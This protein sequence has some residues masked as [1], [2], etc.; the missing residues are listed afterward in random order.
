MRKILNSSHIKWI[1][2]IAMF[3]DHYS[4]RFIYSEPA[5]SIGRS[6]G[7]LAFPLFLFLLVIGYIH[8]RNRRN[9]LI[10]LGIFSVI[11]EIP[12]DLFSA[13][14]MVNWEHQNVF[15]TLIL[16]FLS[17]LLIDYFE[18]KPWLIIVG[19]LVIALLNEFIVLGDYGGYGIVFGAL[20]YYY[21]KRGMNPSLVMFFFGLYQSF[22]AITGVIPYLYNGKKGQQMKYFFYLFYPLHLYLLYYFSV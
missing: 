11:S 5:Y 15:F 13:N 2:I 8:T 3:I 20:I 12:F 18:G 22:G 1:A 17:L 21:I 7:R 9:Y 10:R 6:I 4:Y 16:V 14:Q 19:V